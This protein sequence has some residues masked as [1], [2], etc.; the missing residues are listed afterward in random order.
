MNQKNKAEVSF[1]QESRI[2]S[3]VWNTTSSYVVLES[4]TTNVGNPTSFPQKSS[5][6]SALSWGKHRT[7]TPLD[8]SGWYWKQENVSFS[9]QI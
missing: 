8:S 4:R 1:F 3:D 5:W 7:L 9:F 2:V 6:S